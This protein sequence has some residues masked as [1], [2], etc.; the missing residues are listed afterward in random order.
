MSRAAKLKQDIVKLQAGV[1]RL[2][3]DNA[4]LQSLIPKVMLRDEDDVLD[5]QR[6]I[7]EATQRDER[8]TIPLKT[9]E[10]HRH[11]G[12]VFDEWGIE[13]VAPRFQRE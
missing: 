11:P 2:K 5:H 8:F 6:R 13:T 10:S 12:P 3:H 9:W 1:R 4:R 7:Y